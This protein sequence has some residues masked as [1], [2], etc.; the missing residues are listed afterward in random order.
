MSLDVVVLPQPDSPTSPSVLP[1]DSVNEIES[2]ARTSPACQPSIPPRTGKCLVRFF[3]SRRGVPALTA[4][5][6]RGGMEPAAAHLPVSHWE[7][8]GRLDAAT[9]HDVRATRREGASG[10]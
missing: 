8:R 9:I 2:T 6:S 4:L 7:C 5:P 1:G 10:R 3:T